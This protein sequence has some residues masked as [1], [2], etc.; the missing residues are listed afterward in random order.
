MLSALV[1]AKHHFCFIGPC[2]THPLTA[3]SGRPANSYRGC[4]DLKRVFRLHSRMSVAA[5]GRVLQSIFAEFTQPLPKSFAASSNGGH[6]YKCTCEGLVLMSGAHFPVKPDDDSGGQQKQSGKFT[7]L[8]QLF[9]MQ[10]I[11]MGE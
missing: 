9:L 11:H 7:A 6:N 8:N 2:E 5:S 3:V 10:H 4:V 1:A